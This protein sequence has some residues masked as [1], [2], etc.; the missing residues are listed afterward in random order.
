MSFLPAVQIQI[1]NRQ[2][3]DPVRIT[4][5]Y[6]MAHAVGH[7]NAVPLPTIVAHLNRRGVNITETGFQQTILAESRRRNY[8]I[9]SGHRGYFLID[10]VQ[11]AEQ[12]R[13]FYETRIRREQENL[14]N[15]RGQAVALGWNI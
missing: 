12:M 4:L 5:E 10:T 3:N 14:T 6:M 13:D 7:H 2:A 11:D 8:F 15:L 1:N 9:G